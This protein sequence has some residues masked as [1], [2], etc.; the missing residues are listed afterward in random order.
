[1]KLTAKL[2]KSILADAEKC[3]PRECCGVVIDGNY[4]ACRNIAEDQNQFEIHPEDLANAED[5]GE[6]QAYVHS[7][8]AAS[9]QASDLD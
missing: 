6:I 1:M 7:H 9:A 3:Y 8:P 4:I 5:S 2:K